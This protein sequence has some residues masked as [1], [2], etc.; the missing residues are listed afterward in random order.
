MVGELPGFSCVILL[1]A[2]SGFANSG[3]TYFIGNCAAD[4]L[5]LAWAEC[6]Y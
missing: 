3:V 2:D 6:A 4:V 5:I 1:L